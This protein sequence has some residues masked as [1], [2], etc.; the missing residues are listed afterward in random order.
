MR[1]E[2]SWKGSRDEREYSRAEEAD[3]RRQGDNQTQMWSKIHKNRTTEDEPDAP[4]PAAG[5]DRD[6]MGN[7]RGWQRSA[8]IN[9]DG[10]DAQKHKKLSIWNKSITASP[11]DPQLGEAGPLPLL[12]VSLSLQRR[13]TSC[14][15]TA[16]ITRKRKANSRGWMSVQQHKIHTIIR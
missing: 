9:M 10:G 11:N 16:W 15:E 3:E 7:D 1:R 8:D 6:R 13:N 4:Q 12:P 14:W 2:R 5:S